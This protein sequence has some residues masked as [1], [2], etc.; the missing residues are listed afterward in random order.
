MVIS[1]ERYHDGRG[2]RYKESKIWGNSPELSNGLAK[3][4][5]SLRWPSMLRTESLT[6]LM[7]TNSSQAGRCRLITPGWCMGTCSN[8]S[9]VVKLSARALKLH[10]SFWC[11][12]SSRILQGDP[13]S[14][15]LICEHVDSRLA[16]LLGTRHYPPG[17]WLVFDAYCTFI[18]NKLESSWT[19]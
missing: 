14:R 7:I 13:S 9:V 10:W 18:M 6:A 4:V 1:S 11:R 12:P 19:A 2:G 8:L 17:I 5:V 15:L 3:A 16:R